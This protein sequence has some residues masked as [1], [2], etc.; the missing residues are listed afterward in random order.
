MGDAAETP[1]YATSVGLENVRTLQELVHKAGEALNGFIEKISI[2]YEKAIE[3]IKRA[4]PSTAEK[5]DVTALV[6]EVK[7]TTEKGFGHRIISNLSPVVQYK[8]VDVNKLC[9]DHVVEKAVRNLREL[10]DDDIPDMPDELFDQLSRF[11]KK[12]KCTA[13]TPSPV[14]KHQASP[15]T[16]VTPVK[17]P[18]ASPATP[19]TPVKKPQASTVTPVKMPQVERVVNPLPR[20]EEENSDSE[21]RDASDHSSASSSHPQSPLIDEGSEIESGS[22]TDDEKKPDDTGPRKSPTRTHPVPKNITAMN[23]QKLLGPNYIKFNR[24]MLPALTLS[25][26]T[27]V[28]NKHSGENDPV[29]LELLTQYLPKKKFS[30]FDAETESGAM[31]QFLQFATM[32]FVKVVTE[33]VSGSNVADFDVIFPGYQKTRCRVNRFTGLLGDPAV[34]IKQKQCTTREGAKFCILEEC[35]KASVVNTSNDKFENFVNFLKTIQVDRVPKEA[36]DHDFNKSI[37]N[38]FKSVGLKKNNIP[39]YTFFVEFG[40]F[41][42]K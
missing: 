4:V 15:V 39:A 17:K 13:E 2:V 38:L 7:L 33:L 25:L 22:E 5:G 8:M 26:A 1:K 18:Q 40:R 29:K 37:K 3:D 11:L 6:N 34:L 14:K 23:A 20:N 21:E 42:V 10:N 24:Y 9:K 19:V 28:Y 30:K 12:R 32:V 41:I 31:R 36:M 27:A 16:Q 35:K